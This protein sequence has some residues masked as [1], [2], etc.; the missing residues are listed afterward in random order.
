MEKEKFAKIRNPSFHNLIFFYI[1]EKVVHKAFEAQRNQTQF[2]LRHAQQPGKQGRTNASDSLPEF[3]N[4][5][6]PSPVI[7]TPALYFDGKRA[8]KLQNARTI[9]E[10]SSNISLISFGSIRDISSN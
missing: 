2:L 6:E 3:Y 1:T 10:V 9:R 4:L 5:F 8:W 7:D